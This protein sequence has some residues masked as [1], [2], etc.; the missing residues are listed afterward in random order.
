MQDD[1]TYSILFILNN[2][3]SNIKPLLL[4]IFAIL[5]KRCHDIHVI[6]PKNVDEDFETKLRDVPWIHAYP[7]PIVNN[8][9]P[10]QA[11]L[12]L[13][14]R[15]YIQK[16]DGIDVIH[17]FGLNAG[18]LSYCGAIYLKTAIINTPET[19]SS[20]DKKLP[21]INVLQRFMS[22]NITY[23]FNRLCDKILF[24]SKEDEIKSKEHISFSNTETG[25]LDITLSPEKISDNLI[26]VYSDIIDKV[27][28]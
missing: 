13:E 26:Q 1:K 17:S 11:Y 7:L 21:F 15:K 24:T 6:Y 5:T 25:F 20:E 10:Y 28:T 12:P 18:I 9:A 27:R 16:H 4:K 14:I 19:L 22:D 2:E 8:F 3:M 23:V